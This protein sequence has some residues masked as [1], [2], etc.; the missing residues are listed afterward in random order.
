MRD[1]ESRIKEVVEFR[2]WLLGLTLEKRIWDKKGH[3]VSG[4]VLVEMEVVQ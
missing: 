4:G 2:E 1:V 3:R